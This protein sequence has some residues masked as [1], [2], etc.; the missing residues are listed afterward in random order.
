MQRL[1]NKIGHLCEQILPEGIMKALWK[2]LT[3][4]F[5]TFLVI[6]VINT[7]ST[8]VF[9][10]LLDLV[11]NRCLPAGAAA[12]ADQ[13]RLTFIIGYILSLGVS[14]LL[15][16]YFTFHEKP[17]LKR[18]IKFP[19]SYIPNF[20]IQYLLVYLFTELGWYPTLAYLIAAVVGIPITFLVMKVFVYK[21]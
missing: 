1:L 11:K 10:A 3:V 8:T 9:S 15:N 13:L 16:T 4:E 6:G 5:I 18:L 17:T 14:F 20:V 19:V 21:K 12:A 2:F 7:L